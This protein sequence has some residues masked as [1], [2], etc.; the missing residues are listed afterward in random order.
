[1]ISV[2][3]N[4]WAVLVAAVA[5]QAIAGIWY[6]ALFGQRWQA[7]SGR[8][9]SGVASRA[10]RGQLIAFLCNWVRAG[11]IAWL[12]YGLGVGTLLPAVQLGL[13]I[14]LGL[15]VAGMIPHYYFSGHTRQLLLIDAGQVLAAVLA[16]TLIVS[17]WR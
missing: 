4:Y 12:A 1:M 17:L 11:V 15:A 10:R 9:L 2:D 13:G 7:N 5:A 14:G 16:M 6:S 3:M 8:T